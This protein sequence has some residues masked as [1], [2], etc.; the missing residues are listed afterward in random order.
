MVGQTERRQM[1]G[2]T[3]SVGAT[4]GKSNVGHSR[5]RQRPAPIHGR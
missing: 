1:V 5:A 2:Q 3:D 4:G